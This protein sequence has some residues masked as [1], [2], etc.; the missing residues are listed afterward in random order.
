MSASKRMTKQELKKD[1]FVSFFLRISSFLQRNST[2]T[3]I[4]AV[5][6][7]I[8]LGAIAFFN[9]TAKTREQESINLIGIAQL[10][11]SQGQ[12][13]SAKTNFT[14]A[15]NEYSGTKS[16]K[17]AT[18]YM[19]YISLLEENYDEAENY[20]KDFLKSGIKDTELIPAARGGLAAALEGKGQFK[21]AAEYYIQ[22][23]N[24]YPKFFNND[25]YLMFAGNAFLVAND[26][27]SSIDAFKKI[28][29]EHKNS[30]KYHIAKERFYEL[31]G[32]E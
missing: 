20:Y 14:K 2:Y 18:L 22:T 32:K 27:L 6:I 29:D 1:S 12:L 15:I 4:G 23:V 10:D 25:E 30:N 28:I 26:T 3:T 7:I 11:F 31:G 13:E 8:I 16:A 19:G 5:A 9:W 24:K 17:L 21:E